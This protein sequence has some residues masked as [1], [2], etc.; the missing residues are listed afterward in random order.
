MKL[1]QNKAREGYLMIEVMLV[2]VLVSGALV[3][4]LTDYLEKEAK[5]NG[6]REA[7]QS[8]IAL[9][10][11]LAAHPINSMV[12]SITAGTSVADADKRKKEIERTGFNV[13]SL[14]FIETMRHTIY[15]N[16]INTD[17]K[18]VTISTSFQFFRVASEFNKK[19]TCQSF[20][21]EQTNNSDWH[22]VTIN[23]TKLSL[24]KP[25]PTAKK[26]SDLCISHNEVYR[27]EMEYCY[28]TAALPC[29]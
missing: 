21:N 16:G 26:L 5:A 18:P 7:A 24:G 22:S 12:Q 23:G 6:K 25:K 28:P 8:Q 2:S 27:Y 9:H 20:L 29:I 14:D 17:K 10:E 19:A 3:F 15:R 13:M 1:R 11:A 4:V